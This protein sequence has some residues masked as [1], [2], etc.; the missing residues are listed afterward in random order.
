MKIRRKGKVFIGWE[1]TPDKRIF[2]LFGL[3]LVRR[4]V[5]RSAQMMQECLRI[6]Q[7][8]RGMLEQSRQM[9]HNC[10]QMQQ[11]IQSLLY[12]TY[13]ELEKMKQINIPAAV[14]HPAIFSKYRGILRGEGDAV[15]VGTGPTL[16]AY[17]PIPGA[18]HIGVNRAFMQPGLNL[19]YLIIQDRLDIPDADIIRYRPDCCRKLF[20]KHYQVRPIPESLVQACKAERYYFDATSVHHSG[21]IFPLDLAHEPFLVFGS[22]IFVAVQF[23]LWLHPKRLYIVGCDC[24]LSGYCKAAETNFEQ[25]LALN[26][27]Q[28][29]WLRLRD[30]ARDF[31]PDVE[32]ISINPVGLKGVFRD[33]KMQD[34][35]LTEL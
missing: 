31:Y 6:S 2:R 4:K 34:G 10:L 28:G 27:L 23:A 22:T 24:N 26:E 18:V 16:D 9:Q 14:H 19:D 20:G 3:K 35:Q 5:N 8:H 1:R 32:I 12:R 11:S 15:V 7:E 13:E 21:K 33:C 30:F 29:G 17:A 25:K